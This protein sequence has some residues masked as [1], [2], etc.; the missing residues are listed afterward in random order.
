[1]ARL[2]DS[3]G[4]SCPPWKLLWHISATEGRRGAFQVVN[5]ISAFQL[6]SILCFLLKW[7]LVC[8]GKGRESTLLKTW[9]SCLIFLRSSKWP[10]SWTDTPSSRS[11]SIALLWLANKSCHLGTMIMPQALMKD[12]GALILD[13]CRVKD[14]FWLTHFHHWGS[15][16]RREGRLEGQL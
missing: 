4:C 11:L 5:K 7:N 2:P 6:P 10:S 9:Q 3:M 12:N 1:M 15:E 16:L 8:G 13:K 14:G